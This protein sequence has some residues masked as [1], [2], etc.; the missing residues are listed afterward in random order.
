MLRIDLIGKR[1][2]VAGVADDGGFGFAI[3]KAMA[4]AGASICVG[5]WP[6]AMGIFTKMLEMGKLDASLALSSGDKLRFEKIFPLDAD[7]DTF[8]DIPAELQGS[9]RYRDQGDCSIAGVAARAREQLGEQPF[10]IVVHSLANGPEVKKPL[11]QTSRKGYLAAVGVSAY[12]FTSM[13]QRFGPLMRPGGAFLALSYMAGE[14]VVPGYGGGMSSAK[15]ALESD[16]RTLAYEAGRAWGHRVNVISAGPFAS[17][18]ASAIGFVEVMIDY[19]RRNAPLPEPLAAEEVGAAAA[20]L[21]SP[22]GSG[23]TGTVVYVDKGHHAMGIAVDREGPA[24]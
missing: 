8:E 17:R 9:R 21:C 18:A 22:L 2:L 24:K 7:F 6:P 13:V 3:A 12:S 23:I 14:R 19:A 15:A 4:E 5:T 16:A 11:L 20:F 10:D 1:A